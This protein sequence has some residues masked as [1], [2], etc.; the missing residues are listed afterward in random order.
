[1][2]FVRAWEA[3]HRDPPAS[4]CDLGA[5]G[6][7]PGLV[8]ALAWPTARVGLLEASSRRCRFLREAVETLGLTGRAEV[9][10]G[11]AERLARTEK[12]EGRFELV[13]AR[14][15]GPPATTAECAARLLAPSGTLLVAEPPGDAGNPTRWPA[16]GLGMLGL[17]VAG[18]SA[19]PSLVVLVAIHES[20]ARYPRRDGV[21]LKRPLF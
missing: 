1:M 11:R 12:L 9:H 15:F 3:L 21:P 16:D 17:E 20:P 4:F 2:G 14:S 5:G 18:S 7:V 13:I 8:V 19:S 6:G 10:E